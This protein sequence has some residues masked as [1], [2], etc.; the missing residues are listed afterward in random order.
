MNC[1][2]CGATLEK[3]A[4]FC[5][6]CG[7]RIEPKEP[8]I[9]EPVATPAAESKPT[10][11]VREI[12]GVAIDAETVKN[13]VTQLPKK[14]KIAIGAAAAVILLIIIL[15]A[16]GGKT[17]CLSDYTTVSFTGYDT[18]GKAAVQ[19]DE[20][21]LYAD[22]AQKASKK[23]SQIDWEAWFGD[24]AYRGALANN[25]MYTLSSSEGLCNGDT[26]QLTWT[27]NEDAIKESFGVKVTAKDK[28]YKVSDLPKPIPFDPFEDVAFK[29]EGVDGEGKLSGEITSD[30]SIYEDLYF[31]SDTKNNLSNGDTV[32][33]VLC[34]SSL[35]SSDDVKTYC[36]ENYGMTPTAVSKD[37]TV[38]GLGQYITASSQL[39]AKAIDGLKKHSQEALEKQVSLTQATFKS[40][41]YLGYYTLFP[42]TEDQ[43]YYNYGKKNNILCVYK[44]SVEFNKNGQSAEQEYYTFIFYRDVSINGDEECSADW[45]NYYCPLNTIYAPFVRWGYPY[46][47]GFI[48]LEDLEASFDHYSYDYYVCEAHLDGNV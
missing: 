21:R 45:D 22:F 23:N 2:K 29:F 24:Y 28:E 13:K 7:A 3:G 18:V 1:E 32:T 25:A 48:T 20:D 16:G 43:Y 17:I 14:V 11:T 40:S 35:Y 42:K 44:A 37:Y 41:E 10:E 33:M 34:A 6:N 26:V 4:K 47:N 9:N 15:A 5:Q 46:V 38:E 39:T 36:I 31:D 12:T 19:I 30:K 27:I 8:L